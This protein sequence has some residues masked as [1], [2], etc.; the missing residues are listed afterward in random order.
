M[1]DS[2]VGWSQPLDDI[3]SRGLT[4]QFHFLNVSKV[5]EEEG[6]ADRYDRA[7][8]KWAEVQTDDLYVLWKENIPLISYLIPGIQLLSCEM[9]S[10]FP[11]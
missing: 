2:D 4:N 11:M 9:A 7:T 6:G 10:N 1:V 5:G 8:G 3:G